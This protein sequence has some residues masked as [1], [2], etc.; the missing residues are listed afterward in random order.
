MNL[1][2]APWAAIIYPDD[3]RRGQALTL[4]TSGCKPLHLG[5]LLTSGERWNCH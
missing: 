2:I 4:S 3:S 1:E 5:V